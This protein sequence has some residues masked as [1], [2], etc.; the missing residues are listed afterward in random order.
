MRLVDHCE[1]EPRA[2]DARDL[3]HYHHQFTASSYVFY[4]ILN[5]CD[6]AWYILVKQDCLYDIWIEKGYLDCFEACDF[7]RVSQSHCG[8]STIYIM[9]CV[10][11]IC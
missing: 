2:Q 7:T 5:K 1:A 4:T 10:L 11:T 9:A 8:V 3:C 6:D